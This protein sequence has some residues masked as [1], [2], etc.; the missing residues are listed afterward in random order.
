M[1]RAFAFEKVV[2]RAGSSIK[3][4]HCLKRTEVEIHGG[5]NV[6]ERINHDREELVRK[7][8]RNAGVQPKH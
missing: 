6:V 1:N 5:S 7:A 8:C 3:K 4:L 2:L